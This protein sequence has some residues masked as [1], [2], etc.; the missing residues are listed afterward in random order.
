VHTRGVCRFTL[1]VPESEGTVQN[2][3]RLRCTE[4]AVQLAGTIAG[5]LFLDVDGDGRRGSGE[6]VFDGIRLVA[7]GHEART[8]ADGRFELHDL[9]A[10]AAIEAASASELPAG[11]RIV[12]VSADGDVAVR[13]PAPVKDLGMFVVLD[14]PAGPYRLQQIQ[15][16]SIPLATFVGGRSLTAREDAAVQ[17]LGTDV[18]D[19]DDLRVLVLVHSPAR[20]HKAFA[21]ALRGARAALRYLK[22]PALI[23]P[24]R[25]LWTIDGP[26]ATAPDGQ[27]DVLLV[28]APHSARSE[29][30]AKASCI[31]SAACR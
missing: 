26:D 7:A 2:L 12:G 30:R 15:A 6:P 20:G 9:P 14:L 28:R 1:R 5:R 16:A 27:V 13:R 18:L 4:R 29:R 8:D 3:G 25:I 23:P 19:A 22:G 11:F 24:S 31:R 17:R 21:K 10:G